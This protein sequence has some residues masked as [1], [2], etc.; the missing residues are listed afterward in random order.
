MNIYCRKQSIP[1][2]VT[3]GLS[4]DHVKLTVDALTKSNYKVNK[5]PQRYAQRLFSSKNENQL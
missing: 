3:S 4:S 2:F 1:I 5:V